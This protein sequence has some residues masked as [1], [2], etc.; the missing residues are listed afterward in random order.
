MTLIYLTVYNQD[1]RMTRYQ[2]GANNSNRM[3]RQTFWMA[4]QYVGAFCV[5]F[6]PFAL[7]YVVKIITDGD[8]PIFYLL[9]WQALFSPLQGFL[10]AVVYSNDLR[11]HLHSVG[12]TVAFSLRNMR[13]SISRNLIEGGVERNNEV[14][15]EREQNEVSPI[16]EQDVGTA[17]DMHKMDDAVISQDGLEP[18]NTSSL[19]T[20]KT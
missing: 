4:C 17:T 10:N 11:S 6:I 9:F 2:Y 13:G 5:S 16:S 20:R 18:D 12:Q 14:A 7:M 19:A 1:Q 3:T 8:A 15:A